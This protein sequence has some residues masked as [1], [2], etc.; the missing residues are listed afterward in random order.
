MT[1]ENEPAALVQ[2]MLLLHKEDFDWPLA[3]EAPAPPGFQA[4]L[5]AEGKLPFSHHGVVHLLLLSR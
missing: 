3:I 1:E 5:P 4:D 2:N